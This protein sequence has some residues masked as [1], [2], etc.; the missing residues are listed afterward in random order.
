MTRLH[1]ILQRSVYGNDYEVANNNW[2]TIHE[3]VTQ[4]M[5]TTGEDIPTDV[6]SS[7]YY[8]RGKKNQKPKLCEI[9]IISM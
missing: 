7:V 6:E 8:N 9:F 5:L 2:K 4:D 3:P 1:Y